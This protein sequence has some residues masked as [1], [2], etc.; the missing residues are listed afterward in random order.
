MSQTKK[1]I[2]TTKLLGWG[3]D[4]SRFCVTVV[5][6][7]SFVSVIRIMNNILLPNGYGKDQILNVHPGGLKA[8]PKVKVLYGDLRKQLR[9]LLF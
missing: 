7:D 5:D 9:N 6:P 8:S 3:E 1:K 4:K 2:L